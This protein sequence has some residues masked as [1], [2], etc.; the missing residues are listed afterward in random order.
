VTSGRG[1]DATHDAAA[2]G[3][4]RMHWQ[5]ARAAYE[6][7]EGAIA[8]L[9]PE[10][11]AATDARYDDFLASLGPDGDPEPFDGE[12]V[13]GMHAIERILWVEDV[14]VVVAEFE[15]GLPG[16]RAAAYPRTEAEAR[17]FKEQLAARMVR[18]VEALRSQLVPLT[19]DVAFVLRGLLD[20]AAEQ[21]EKVD[22]AATGQEESRYAQTTL[23]DLRDNRRGC[24]D[25]YRLFRPWLLSRP[26]GAEVDRRVLA[27]FE[28][29]DRAYDAIPG[30]AIPRPPANMSRLEPTEAHLQT[31]FG[32]LFTTVRRESDDAVPGSLRAS[33]REVSEVLA[34]PS[35]VAR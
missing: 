9:F 19:L 2:L 22:R 12:G 21:F 15:R 17:A 34:L 6:R 4:M 11:D 8:P 7:I 5:R 10:S 16:H 30:H 29:L 33:L 3:E 32:R 24:Y 1:W 23:D 14:P 25:A 28:R 27:A 26:R 20:L 18:D 13:I 31:P 35:V